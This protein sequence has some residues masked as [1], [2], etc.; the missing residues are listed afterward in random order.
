MKRLAV[1]FLALLTVTSIFAFMFYDAAN[2]EEYVIT[3]YFAT[4]DFGIFCSFIHTSF[5]TATIFVIID[6]DIGKILKTSKCESHQYC[7]DWRRSHAI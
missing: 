3:A 6:C 4:T 1:A 2:I 7:L 5:E